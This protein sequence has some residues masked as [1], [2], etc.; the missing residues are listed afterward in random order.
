MKNT[1]AILSHRKTYN[2]HFVKSENELLQELSN[3]TNVV[4]VIDRKIKP[5]YP[6]ITAEMQS[7]GALYEM[8]A[9]EQNKTLAGAEEILKFFQFANVDRKTTVLVIG[10]GI[11]EDVVSFAAHIFYRGLNVILVPT[12]LLAMCD[13]CVGGKCG[14]N[15]NGYKNQLGAI[16]PPEKIIIW[17]GFLTS[18]SDTDIR[19][20]Y[21]E[22]LK[23]V[24]LNGKEQ[25][26]KLKEHLFNAHLLDEQCID[27]IHDGIIT[28]KKL[29]EEDE[30]DTGMRALLNYGHTFGH[31][32]ERA[33]HN[34][35]PH[36]IAVTKGIDIANY[37]A[38]QLGILS[39]DIYTDIHSLIQKHFVCQLSSDISAKILVENTQ[40]DKKIQNG[41]SHFVLMEDFGKFKIVPVMINNEFI[42]IM[43]NYLLS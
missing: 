41:K 30:F 8:D 21:G 4:T 9:F 13:T 27:Y 34:A 38:W 26:T 42:H 6:K 43:N 35:I 3:L 12:T 25:Y 18:L 39:Q 17:P 11:L 33:T 7:L 5:F 40:K 36:G 1:L 16:H 20:G 22:I 24:L 37:I 32:I 31:A 2:V 28:K 23:Y 29:V 14:V 19:S 15:F 10:G